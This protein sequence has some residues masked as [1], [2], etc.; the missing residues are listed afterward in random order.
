MTTY[1][2]HIEETLS[3][4]RTVTIEA[5]SHKDAATKVARDW[6][7]NGKPAAA[8]NVSVDDRTYEVSDEKLIECFGTEVEEETDC[9]VCTDRSCVHCQAFDA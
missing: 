8:T 1:E 7:D 6:L 2:V 3:E 9:L 4:T 5:D